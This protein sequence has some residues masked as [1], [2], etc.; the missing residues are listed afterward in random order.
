MKTTLK[1]GGASIITRGLSSKEEGIK[2]L[3]RGHS[4]RP[5]SIQKI[6]NEPKRY[7]FR[8]TTAQAANPLWWKPDMLH[9]HITSKL[10]TDFD[11]IWG[12]GVREDDDMLD[13]PASPS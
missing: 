9:S 11:L 10:I 7:S 2:V 5:S 1:D 12:M 13:D 3:F 8:Y 6:L 4:N